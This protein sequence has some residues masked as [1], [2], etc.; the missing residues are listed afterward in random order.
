[1]PL[2]INPDGTVT[3][4]GDGKSKIK[5]ENLSEPIYGNQFVAHAASGG[6][7]FESTAPEGR[8]NGVVEGYVVI[9]PGMVGMKDGEDEGTIILKD[10][11]GPGGDENEQYKVWFEYKRGGA[12]NG[13]ELGREHRHPNTEEIE[14]VVYANQPN[15]DPGEKL[16]FKASYQDTNDEGVRLRMDYKDPKT[17]EWKKLFD[18]VDYGDGRKGRPYRGKSGVQDGI[19]VDGSVDG[20]F[21]DDDDEKL[22]NIRNKPIE[23]TI[24]TDKQKKILA[25][26]ASGAIWAREIEMDNSDLNDGIDDPLSFGP[27]KKT[28]ND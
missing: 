11:H 8:A 10:N 4:P 25:K 27:R 20:K 17:G 9:P 23:S 22:R 28:E 7:T 12:V 19:R 1:M 3:L 21:S 16:E 26:L 24:L 13:I 15:L 5:N 2:P 18:H 6:G 14:E